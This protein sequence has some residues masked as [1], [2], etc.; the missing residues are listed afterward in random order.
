MVTWFIKEILQRACSEKCCQKWISFSCSRPEGNQKCLLDL[1]VL[2]TDSELVVASQSGQKRLTLGR[3]LLSQTDVPF[4]GSA[5]SSPKQTK[6]TGSH[7]HHL[8]Q[9]GSRGCLL[10]QWWISHIG[11][12]EGKFRGFCSTL[13]VL[14]RALSF[15]QLL[16]IDRPQSKIA[17]GIV[18]V[19]YS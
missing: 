7:H 10:S 16:S 17:S 13:N 9:S 3:L 5:E 8:Q 18:V 2:W 15:G 12:Y 6:K 11:F 4:I 19:A 14:S 1:S